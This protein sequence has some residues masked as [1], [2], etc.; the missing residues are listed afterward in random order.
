M[1]EFGEADT[2][3]YN[4][5]KQYSWKER[6]KRSYHEREIKRGEQALH[7]YIRYG[8]LLSGYGKFDMQSM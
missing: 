7:L 5:K 2:G 1:T 4:T 8:T 3:E 6:C